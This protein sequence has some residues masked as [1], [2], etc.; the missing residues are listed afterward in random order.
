MLRETNHMCKFISFVS[1]RSINLFM[2]YRQTC[3]DP[4]NSA[5]AGPENFLLVTIV[6]H[7]GTFHWPYGPLFEGSV[8]VFV[9]FQVGRIAQQRSR[10][11]LTKI[12]CSIAVLRACPFILGPS[13]TGSELYWKKKI[14]VCRVALDHLDLYLRGSCLLGFGS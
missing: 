13:F 5:R 4:E 12:C 8:P 7:G 6:F 2:G 10:V 1:L 11:D 9:I 3:A 14:K